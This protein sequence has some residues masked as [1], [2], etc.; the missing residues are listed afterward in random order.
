MNADSFTFQ[1][2]EPN[3]NACTKRTVLSEVNGVFDPIG[4]AAPVII[5][6]KMLLRE[7]TKDGGGWDDP[8]PKELL[9]DWMIWRQSLIALT[10]VRD[11][12]SFAPFPTTEAVTRELHTLG[13]ASNKAIGAVCYLRTVGSNDEVHVQLVMGK[14]KL[15]PKAAGT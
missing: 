12:R 1:I 6:G 3:A 8:L 5:K 13:D 9:R 15:A 2:A 11:L 10:D 14:A 4:L 7:M